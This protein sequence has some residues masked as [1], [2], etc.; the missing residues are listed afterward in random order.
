EIENK[1][2]VAAAVLSGNRNFE[3]RISSHVKANYLASPPLVVA[4]ALA[5]TIAIDMEKEP[6]GN[7]KEGNPVYLKD[8]W[9]SMNEIKALT[10][11]YVKPSL[12]HKEYGEIFKGW[13]LW[14]ELKPPREDIYN[15]DKQSTYIREPPYFINFPLNKPSLKDITDARVLALL[16]T[17]VT[18]DHI[19]PAGAISKDMPAGKYLLSKGVKF[20]D[21]NS[22]G[23]R[24]G[25]HEV[26]MRG[27][28]GNIRIRNILVDLE[29][30]WTL[31]FLS[32]KI[33]TI[34]DAAM[35]Y[36]SKNI[37]LI[38][39]AGE[40]YGMGSSRDWAAKGTQLLGVKAVIAK[41]F[42]RIHRSNLV[43]MGVLPLEF[44]KGKNVKKLGLN[45][46]EIYSITGITEM[47]PFS[48]VNITAIKDNGE[49]IEFKAIVRLDSAVDIEYF[50]NGGILHTVLRK[51]LNNS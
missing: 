18:T 14:N 7:D 34:Y 1:D 31:N 27:T 39:L 50:Q 32:N 33:D 43:G 42:E 15:W 51:M 8:I 49:K 36:L 12:F 11:K 44:K 17:S 3:G 48:E 47:K 28:F 46:N 45:G 30:G 22:F 5:G 40:D 23:S 13:D 41:S 24:R 10:E 6:L 21:F 29:G 4:F 38:V 16:G 26:M 2:L 25:N 19:S 9:P 35:D 20:E 37:P